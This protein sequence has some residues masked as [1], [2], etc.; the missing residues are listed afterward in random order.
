[1]SLAEVMPDHKRGHYSSL[2]T[3]FKCS[4]CGKNIIQS[5][6]NY[7]PC[8]SS[9]MKIDNRGNIHS[10]HIRYNFSIQT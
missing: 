10:K 8:I 4:K 6:S 5:V 9:A 1:M 3:L 2:A 7:V